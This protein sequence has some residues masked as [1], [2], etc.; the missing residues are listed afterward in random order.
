MDSFYRTLITHTLI[1][2]NSI[3]GYRETDLKLTEID[4]SALRLVSQ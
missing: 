2:L 3:T 4:L 1:E